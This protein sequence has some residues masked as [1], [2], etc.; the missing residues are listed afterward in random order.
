MIG[1]SHKTNLQ[2]AAY[3]EF[4]YNAGTPHNKREECPYSNSED[5]DFEE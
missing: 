1:K 4:G 5:G 3:V 2:R